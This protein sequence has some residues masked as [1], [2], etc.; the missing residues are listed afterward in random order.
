MPQLT[1]NIRSAAVPR[2]WPS[3]PTIEGWI[4]DAPLGRGRFA[5]VYAA[6]PANNAA[7]EAAAYAIKVLSPECEGSP[8]AVDTMRREVQA[9]RAA[10]SPHLA[11]V[12]SAQL[13]SAPYYIVRPRLEGV[14]LAAALAAR[15]RPDAPLAI[16]IARQIA[17]A[18][19]ALHTAG[20]LHGDVKPSNIIVSPFGHATLFDLGL[21]QTTSQQGAV[22]D[23][24]AGA[25]AY[26]A[27]EVFSP[28]GRQGAPSDV[29]SL[30]AI[31]VELFTNQPL[32]DAAPPDRSER[33]KTRSYSLRKLKA[34]A[35]FGVVDLL[36]RMLARE[37]LRRP[38]AADVRRELERY[39]IE[40]LLERR[41]GAF[42]EMRSG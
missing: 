26:L 7:M 28:S 16:W 11:T 13:D 12:L 19:D 29:Y 31:L 2:A 8:A 9:C 38:V 3:A 33:L 15:W 40:T 4:L 25:A 32:F 30:G 21:A 35:P 41:D 20:W 14:D 24:A 5:T 1:R 39:E 22:T 10:A 42:D 23:F 18:L 37:P 6:R 34:A 27:P 17:D 36:S